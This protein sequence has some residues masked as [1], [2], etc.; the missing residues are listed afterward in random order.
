MVV[1]M[2]GEMKERIASL[3]Q[4]N[5]R[6]EKNLGGLSRE[7]SGLKE[8]RDQLQRELHELRGGRSRPTREARDVITQLQTRLLE[9]RR[10]SAD[11]LRDKQDLLHDIS[12]DRDRFERAKR[13]LERLR[14]ELDCTLRERDEVA[15]ELT[16]ATALL[17][18]MEQRLGGD[19]PR[20]S[21]I[22]D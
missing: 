1:H 7:V 13:R 22:F 21:A 17:Q 12:R 18:Q 9:E 3:V 11:L 10:R 20:E 6:L 4:A 15:S 5:R 14:G 19:D 8:E 2:V 16:A